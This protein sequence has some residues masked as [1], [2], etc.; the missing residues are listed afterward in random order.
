MCALARQLAES[1][2]FPAHPP[3]QVTCGRLSRSHLPYRVDWPHHP[4]EADHPLQRSPARPLGPME[5]PHCP[6]TPLPASEVH[7][8]CG[9]HWPALPAVRM[10]PAPPSPCCCGAPRQALPSHRN[11][12]TTTV[13]TGQAH[14]AWGSVPPQRPAPTARRK[15]LAVAAR[16]SQACT[17]SGS[18]PLPWR[19]LDCAKLQFGFPKYTEKEKHKQD[20]EAQKPFPVKATGEFT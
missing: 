6:G 19:T 4:R 8:H 18:T 20:E 12:I 3:P 1:R 15:H 14:L 9:A 2:A 5:A 13:H 7:R 10:P 16:P 17:P 11:C